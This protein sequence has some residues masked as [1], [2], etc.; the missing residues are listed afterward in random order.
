MTRAELKE[1]LDDTLM[2]S[3]I[4]MA[5]DPTLGN[6]KRDQ[7]RCMIFHHITNEYWDGDYD[8]NKEI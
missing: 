3:L 7:M 5:K 6:T 8:D 1:N 4:V 2:N